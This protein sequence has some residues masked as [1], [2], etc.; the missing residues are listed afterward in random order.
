MIPEEGVP[1]IALA[2]TGDDSNMALTAAMSVISLVLLAVTGMIYRKCRKE[3][4][5]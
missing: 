3:L 4:Q 1:L 5:K 2:R